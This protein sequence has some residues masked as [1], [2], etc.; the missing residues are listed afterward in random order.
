MNDITAV[1]QSYVARIKQHLANEHDEIALVKRIEEAAP[2]GYTSLLIQS[3]KNDLP[4]VDW[5]SDVEYN[6]E[7][8][9]MD[10]AEAEAFVRKRAAQA[11]F[12]I[13]KLIE[14]YESSVGW[15]K[16]YRLILRGLLLAGDN[17]SPVTHYVDLDTTD[18]LQVSQIATD[19]I[20]GTMPAPDNDGMQWAVE[21]VSIQARV[22]AG[23]QQVIRDWY[24][25]APVV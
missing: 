16:E 25:V 24:G 11:I 10:D 21:D 13:S 15:Y 22:I 9:G 17:P 20:N 5:E 14:K 23:D 12:K 19:Y 6:Y 3:I 7:L 1:E 18:M 2:Q 8:F 4:H